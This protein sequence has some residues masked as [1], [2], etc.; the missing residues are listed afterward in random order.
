MGQS[1][2]TDLSSGI[3]IIFAGWPPSSGASPLR[4]H[5]PLDKE[6][7]ILLRL[8]CDIERLSC[9]RGISTRQQEWSPKIRVRVFLAEFQHRTLQRGSFVA[10]TKQMF[11]KALHALGSTYVFDIPETYQNP[12]G[13][14]KER[15]AHQPEQL[16]SPYNYVEAGAAPA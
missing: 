11:I 12:V 1:R 10:L 13:A 14:S 9:Y 4:C 16:V 3:P 8:H 15:S 5:D 6:I 2:P 7:W